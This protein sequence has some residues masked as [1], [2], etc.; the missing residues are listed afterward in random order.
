MKYKYFGTEFVRTRFEGV[1]GKIT[2]SF[3]ENTERVDPFTVT[4]SKSGM[5]FSGVLEKEIASE[6][7]LQDFA[8]F[9]SDAWVEA[10]KLAPKIYTSIAGH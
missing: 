3:T 8:K 1:D 4:I 2:V 5:K 9:I 6:A 10:R 7:E